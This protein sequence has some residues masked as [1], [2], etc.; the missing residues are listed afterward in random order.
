MLVTEKSLASDI[1]WLCVESPPPAPTIHSRTVLFIRRKQLF[2]R[3]WL[4]GPTPTPRFL[5]IPKKIRGTTDG[6]LSLPAIRPPASAQSHWS[7]T[8]NRG[9]APLTAPRSAIFAVGIMGGRAVWLLAWTRRGRAGSGGRQ[10]PARR[11]DQPGRACST[12][13]SRTSLASRPQILYCAPVA[14]I[15]EVFDRKN[16]WQSASAT[17]YGWRRSPVVDTVAANAVS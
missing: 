5:R 4:L 8:S 12:E 16:S 11:H 14:A 2:I 10:R 1:R 15:T 9:M 17:G 7:R 6:K 13:S 3:R